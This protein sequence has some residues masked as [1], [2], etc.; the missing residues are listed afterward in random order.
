MLGT[1]GMQ[2]KRREA[3]LELHRVGIFCADR[4]TY[5]QFF[6]DGSESAGVCFSFF[7]FSTFFSFVS[8]TGLP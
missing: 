3:E 8:F 6:F 5:A 2:L 1:T 7:S 4:C